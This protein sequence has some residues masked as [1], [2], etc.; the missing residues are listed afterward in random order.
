VGGS[1]EHSN[2]YS[3]SEQAISCLSCR[4]TA[5]QEG[6]CV[7]TSPIQRCVRS[8]IKRASEYSDTFKKPFG[9]L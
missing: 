7:I 5:I 9:I 4:L 1:Y 8:S 6:L 3:G 2:K